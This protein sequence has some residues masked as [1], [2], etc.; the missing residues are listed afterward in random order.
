MLQIV[1]TAASIAGGDVNPVALTTLPVTGGAAVLDSG[2]VTLSPAPVNV[3]AIGPQLL[4]STGNPSALIEFPWYLDSGAATRMFTAS[5]GVGKVTFAFPLG[6]QDWLISTRTR[7]GR[8]TAGVLVWNHAIMTTP[9]PGVNCM[10]CAIVK[11]GSS[12]Y[13]FAKANPNDAY[14]NAQ[15]YYTAV[16]L[17]GVTSPGLY[18]TWASTTVEADFLSFGLYGHEAVPL[19]LPD[20][21]LALVGDATFSGDGVNVLKKSVIVGPAV[22]VSGGKEFTGYGVGE[23]FDGGF[24]RF[25][26]AFTATLSVSSG[27]VTDCVREYSPATYTEAAVGGLV[28][29]GTVPNMEYSGAFLFLG[30]PPP[31]PPFWTN[32]RRAIEVI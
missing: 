29:A 20:F 2:A 4:D 7:I 25:F 12:Y 22:D 5:T 11:R 10:V 31:V 24:S 8:V 30:E 6:E 14:A 21:D 23:T 13:V 32:L 3:S 18:N 19:V 26:G 27:V 17:T 16:D 9:T 1:Y 15:V 28:P